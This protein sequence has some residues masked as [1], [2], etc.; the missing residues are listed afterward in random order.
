MTRLALAALVGL[1][2][3]CASQRGA[4][5]WAPGVLG[6]QVRDTGAELV[7]QVTRLEGGPT[8]LVAPPAATVSVDGAPIEVPPSREVSLPGGWRVVESRVPRPPVNEAFE[9]D[10]WA[11]RPLVGGPALAVRLELPPTLRSG[12]PIEISAQTLATGEWQALEGTRCE[13]G[14]P[15]AVWALEGGQCAPVV[16]AIARARSLVPSLPGGLVLIGAAAS[17]EPWVQL[18]ERG[19][20]W[21]FV[22]GTAPVPTP[23]LTESVLLSAQAELDGAPNL[24]EG[25]ALALA[26]RT[27][28]DPIGVVLER[29]NEAA[30]RLAEAPPGDESNR[31][32]ARAI[33]WRWAAMR[34]ALEIDLALRDATGGTVGLAQVVRSGPRERLRD[35]AARVDALAGRPVFD[36]PPPVLDRS[37]LQRLFGPPVAPSE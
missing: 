22:H 32:G 34:R 31:N 11:L 25:V 10:R 9:S 21:A 1:L 23:E 2:G 19:G 28:A 27:H 7:V 14:A 4:V 33:F 37:N 5:R 13:G 3:A 16:D 15:F 8:V 12:W 20:S 18:R 30:D 29:L 26:A 35:F 6:V 36:A 24:R 17:E